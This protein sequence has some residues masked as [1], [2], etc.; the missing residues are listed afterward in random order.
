MR[1]IAAPYAH[2]NIKYIPLGGL[3]IAKIEPYLQ[4]PLVHAL[5]GSWIAPRELIAKRD[6]G[7]ITNN[8]RLA[9]QIIARVREG[10][11]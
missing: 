8:A 11:V 3:D 1:N 4:E 10:K 7:A 6:W 2:L 5:G 9:T